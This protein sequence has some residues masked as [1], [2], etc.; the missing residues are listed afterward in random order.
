MPTPAY[1]QLQTYAKAS[2]IDQPFQSAG[3]FL[4]NLSATVTK[5]ISEHKVIYIV[6][7]IAAIGFSIVGYEVYK[8]KGKSHA[9]KR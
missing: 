6:S 3:T 4:S 2:G 5:N 8:K 1:Q 9:R 7:A